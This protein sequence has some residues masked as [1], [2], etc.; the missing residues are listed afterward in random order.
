MTS[1]GVSSCFIILIVAFCVFYLEACTHDS[2]CQLNCDHLGLCDLTIGKCSCL[3]ISD[4]LSSTIV[5]NVAAPNAAVPNA[6]VPNAT[7]PNT[8][9]PNVVVPNVAVPN[10]AVPD[11]AVPNVAVPNVAIPNAAVPN[12]AV[13]NANEKCV[14]DADCAN[15]CGPTCKYY[16]CDSVFCICHCS[17]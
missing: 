7:I 4:P 5:P 16:K 8:A 2:E 12:A 3:L 11:V 9:V 14:D 17:E 1:F 6:A 10:A 15:F 13:P